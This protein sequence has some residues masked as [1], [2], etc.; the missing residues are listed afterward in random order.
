MPNNVS[1]N[2]S[3][4][5][6]DGVKV[7][8][9]FTIDLDAMPSNIRD[10]YT[11][12]SLIIDLQK[13]F[14]KMKPEQVQA[15]N[16]TAVSYLMAKTRFAKVHVT[17]EQAMQMS[18]QRAKTDPEY[19]AKLLASLRDGDIKLPDPTEDLDPNDNTEDTEE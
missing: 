8:S 5:D 10:E 1:F 12:R 2:T 13:V 11:L 14:R 19:K 6:S 7:A 3:I 17:D 18:L 15:L 16:G 4:P 9:N